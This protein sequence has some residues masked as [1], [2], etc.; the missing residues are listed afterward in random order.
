[1]QNYATKT[2]EFE[3]QVILIEFVHWTMVFIILF[4]VHMTFVVCI[5]K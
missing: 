2:F 1:M 3:I 5:M 4:S